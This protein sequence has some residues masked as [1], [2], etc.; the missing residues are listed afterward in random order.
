[1]VNPD[2]FWALKGGGGST[3][4]VV[5]QATVN[6][7][8][9]TRRAMFSAWVNTTASAPDSVY[10]IASSCFE[11]L[12][13]LSVYLQG[14]CFIYPRAVRLMAWTHSRGLADA[15][16]ETK[17]YRREWLKSMKKL[18]SLENIASFVHE[19]V[20]YRSFKEF[21]DGTFGLINQNSYEADDRCK[22]K[23][24]WHPTD[25]ECQDG[26]VR[27]ITSDL[28]LEDTVPKKDVMD[29]VSCKMCISS[30]TI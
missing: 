24:E 26:L 17:S 19:E 9:D 13:Q 15:A 23:L 25:Y 18:Q 2:L 29:P 7:W 21:Y 6:T 20:P 30:L 11:E 8:P 27:R 3:F 4:G 1:L 5:V 16:L 28:E 12:E 14:Y 22:R 10:R